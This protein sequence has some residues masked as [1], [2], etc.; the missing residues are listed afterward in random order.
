MP[1]LL[2]KEINSENNTS[3]VLKSLLIMKSIFDIQS[4]IKEEFAAFPS[5]DEKFKHLIKIARS[6][7]G[8]PED[9]KD[10]KFL[11]KGCATRLFLVPEFT[12][13]ALLYHTD[14]DEGDKAPLIVRG[15]ASLAQRLYSGQAPKKIL[16]TDPKFF[17]DLGITVALSPTRANGFGLLL[18]EL[19]LYAT[20][21][22]KLGERS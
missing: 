6:H 19:Y 14:T 21:Y 4:E 22:S 11:I 20:I 12:G 17:Q 2:L 18:K 16:E 13:E 10:E 15:L 8:M 3:L 9:K 5:P 1:L 7:G